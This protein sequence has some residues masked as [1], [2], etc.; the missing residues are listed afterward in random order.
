MEIITWNIYVDDLQ[1]NHK[2]DMILGRDILSKLKI[3]L[4]LFDHGIWVNGNEYIVC[5]SLM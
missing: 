4:W 2:Y 3:D 1:S 5:T